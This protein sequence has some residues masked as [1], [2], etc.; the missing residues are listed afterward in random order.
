ME[1]YTSEQWESLE[2]RI[3]EIKK[4]YKEGLTKI[5]SEYNHWG[6]TSN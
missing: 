3:K 1:T 2:N 5:K 6:K 4:P